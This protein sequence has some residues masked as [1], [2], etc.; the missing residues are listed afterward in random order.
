MVKIF[1]NEKTE[2]K[3]LVLAFP[4]AGHVNELALAYAID[5]SA[6]KECGYVYTENSPIAI[7]NDGKIK[8]PISLFSAKNSI[9]LSSFIPATEELIKHLIS[10]YK[11]SKFAGV[12]LLESMP[13]DVK[14]N[15][16]NVFYV[17]EGDINFDTTGMKSLEEGIIVGSSANLLLA[18]AN[19]KIPTLVVLTEAHIEMPDG[20][21]AANLLKSL[22]PLLG[23][24]DTEELIK[25]YKRRLYKI[26]KLISKY[27]ENSSQ[28]EDLDSLHIYG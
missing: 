24:I 3:L 10:W 16:S 8:F 17:K 13:I 20:I 2:G 6:I 5:K 19:D 1:C 22:Q 25:D 4:A 7:I 15:Q 9:I 18:L 26:H 21:A 12:I 23:E 28:K 27:K 11:E 14:S